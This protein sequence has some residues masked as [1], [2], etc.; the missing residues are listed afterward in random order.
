[1]WPK[2]DPQGGVQEGKDKE[3][4]EERSPVEEEVLGEALKELVE[5]L[6]KEK[7]TKAER[8]VY[9]G[10]VEQGR[11]HR[12]VA[13]E[14]DLSPKGVPVHRDRA[15]TKIREGTRDR[16]LRFHLAVAVGSLVAVLAKLLGFDSKAIVV[17]VPVVV[18]VFEA[19]AALAKRLRE[20]R[21]RRSLG[22]P[23]QGG[24]EDEQD[25]R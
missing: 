12:H 6:K 16:W 7:L 13:E 14:H 23:P 22:E 10:V 21:A 2:E 25:R 15:L 5:Q 18:L 24:P 20:G 3:R 11:P 17:T 1:M 19:C 8:V 4:D 9:E